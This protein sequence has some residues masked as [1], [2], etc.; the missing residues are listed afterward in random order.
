[1][2]SSISR[3]AWRTCASSSS[4]EPRAERLLA[5]AERSSR[6]R[7]RASA[8]LERLALARGEP[9]LVLERAHVAVDLGEVLGQL[10]LALA[11]LLARRGDDRRVQAQTAG[12]F[13]RQA[14]ARR[15]V[16]ELVGR[17]E[18]V[19]VESERRAA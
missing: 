16:D 5:V 15:S 13:E 11:Q 18:R 8:R 9:L 4:F 1:M 14:A 2:T 12:D 3:R 19:G 17:R 7:M 10:R 6:W